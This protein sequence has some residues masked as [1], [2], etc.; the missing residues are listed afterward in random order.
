MP[1][2]RIGLDLT[3]RKACSSRPLGID[4]GEARPAIDS[5]QP[6]WPA[7]TAPR[8]KRNASSLSGSRTL[9]HTRLNPVETIEDSNRPERHRRNMILERPIWPLAE[10]PLIAGYAGW[11]EAP[12]FDCEIARPDS[13]VGDERR[14]PP[15][16]I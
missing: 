14:R 13:L 10:V 6:Q 4:K 3:P 5:W 9:C 15:H 2:Q 8:R 16:L 11:C 1:I 7:A 12:L